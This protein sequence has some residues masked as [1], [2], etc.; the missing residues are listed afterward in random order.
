MA[1]FT[2][3]SVADQFPVGTSVGA[4]LAKQRRDGSSPSGSAVD[5]QTVPATGI[6]TFHGLDYETEY[7]AYASVG[8]V[9]RYR[10]FS[11]DRPVARTIKIVGPISDGHTITYNG[12]LDAFVSAGAVIVNANDPRFGLEADTDQEDQHDALQAAIDYAYEQVTAG[13]TAAFIHV[14]VQGTY[15]FG[16][17]N[18]P[19]QSPSVP[20]QRM[21]ACVWMYEN[22]HLIGNNGVEFKAIDAAN[23]DTDCYSGAFITTYGGRTRSVVTTD[24][25]VEGITL[26]GNADEQVS[27]SDPNSAFDGAFHRGIFVAKSKNVVIRNVVGRNFYG[28]G[29]APPEESFVFDDYVSSNTRYENCTVEGTESS[30]FSTS[31]SVGS[32][33]INCVAYDCTNG[34]GFPHHKSSFLVFQGCH[35]YGCGAAGFNAECC[36]EVAYSAC[37]SG[38][39]TAVTGSAA[40]AP[41]TPYTRKPNN[42]GFQVAG[43]R[44]VTWDANCQAQYNTTYDVRVQRWTAG[45]P[46]LQYPSRIRFG[47]M[48]AD[49]VSVESAA[50]TDTTITGDIANAT[51][52]ITNISGSFGQGQ[53]IVN[54]N[55]PAGTTIISTSGT[56]ATVS[57]NATGTAAGATVT[58]FSD[59]FGW[60]RVA[61]PGGS[62]VDKLIAPG[63][64]VLVDGGTSGL[65]TWY[66]NSASNT[67]V[68]RELAYG[69]GPLGVGS[70]LGYALTNHAEL[71]TTSGRVLSTRVVTS[72]STILVTDDVIFVD[73]ATAAGT[74]NLT[75][76]SSTL[77]VNLRTGKRFRIIDIGNNAGT[78]NIV[79]KVA[80]SQTFLGGSTTDKT[81]STNGLGWE[82]LFADLSSPADGTGVYAVQ[83]T[84]W[85]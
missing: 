9:H 31:F 19:G 59:A 80:G 55:F 49:V 26:D 45:S 27:R 41:M 11:T 66:Q 5:T 35:A 23:W 68:N 58:V 1:P 46:S 13:A 48:I 28:G 20:N 32:R 72:D 50:I 18:I 64:Q 84:T 62:F 14:T 77:G 57:A 29:S 22:L 17:H 33:W 81:I 37:I 60:A 7:V 38:G 67:L 61:S 52:T 76:P 12:E 69:A 25:S 51:N 63:G 53:E 71:M 16:L 43:S 83:E 21:C 8:G 56:T 2:L 47:G 74:V 85:T 79:L 15:W 39:R 4:Y 36:E 42:I 10:N 82:V 24:W 70:G 40:Y 34:Y 78:R 6:L 30:G 54:A 65:R 75:L 44:S 73:T 3:A